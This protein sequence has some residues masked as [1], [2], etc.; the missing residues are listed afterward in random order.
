[1][2]ITAR[3]YGGENGGSSIGISFSK[4]KN[5]KHINHHIVATLSEL[6]GSSLFRFPISKRITPSYYKFA[7]RLKL[8]VETYESEICS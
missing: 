4:T 8:K 6:S 5:W 7:K 3:M 2:K 1:M